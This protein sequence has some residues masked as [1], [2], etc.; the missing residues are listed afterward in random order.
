[1]TYH[2]GG[3]GSES[4]CAQ[5]AA[6]AKESTRIAQKMV[7]VNQMGGGAEKT[8]L[9]AQLLQSWGTGTGESYA[10]MEAR[11]LGKKNADAAAAATAT[12]TA[13]E[14]ARVYETIFQTRKLGG[15]PAKTAKIAAL[16][17]SWALPGE[18]YAAMEA[19]RRAKSNADGA[20]AV[21]ARNAAAE[22]ARVYNTMVRTRQMAGGD[23]KT[24]LI[25]QLRASWA[26]GTG[27]GWGPMMARW[28]VKRAADVAAAAACASGGGTAAPAPGADAGGGAPPA[29]GTPGAP[30]GP[31]VEAEGG[32]GLLGL[33]Y[34]AWG[35]GGAVVLLGG[36]FVV[37]RLKNKKAAAPALP[38]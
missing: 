20:A 29:P 16:M 37:R 11:W 15:S 34:W 17:R 26:Q 5:L 27:E 13:A 4:D 8:R 35:V 6:A 14:S 1:M 9:I 38:K 33:P 28:G 2:L 3:L 18:D 25:A 30:P 10:S 31:P 36:A 32:G 21:A 22:S 24:R 23:E 12:A 19:R 7:E